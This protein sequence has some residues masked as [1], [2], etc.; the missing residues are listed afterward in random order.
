[1]VAPQEQEREQFDQILAEF[2][3]IANI[4]AAQVTQEGGSS[5][6]PPTQ[7][8]RQ[9]IYIAHKIIGDTNRKRMI[10]LLS[11]GFLL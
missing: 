3:G 1:M 7:P 11:D 2:E 9:E 5:A 6:V 8:S 10:D 4:P